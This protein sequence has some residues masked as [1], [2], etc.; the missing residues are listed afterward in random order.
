MT[1][2]LGIAAPRLTPMPSACS[3]RSRWETEPW[4]AGRNAATCLEPWPPAEPQPGK[5]AFSD[6]Q[7]IES[8][9]S[10]LHG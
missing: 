10:T 5:A 6:C 9:S 1:G 8:C 7:T 3:R 4:W 2:G